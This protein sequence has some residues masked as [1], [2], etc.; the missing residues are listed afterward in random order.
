MFPHCSPILN[1]NLS[2]F[3]NDVCLVALNLKYIFS[4]NIYLHIVIMYIPS[5]LITCMQYFRYQHYPDSYER[6]TL[7]LVL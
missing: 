7:I 4:Q 1:K 2:N 5:R 3:Y 6:L